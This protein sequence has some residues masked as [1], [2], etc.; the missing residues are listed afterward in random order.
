MTNKLTKKQREILYLLYRF[1]FLYRNH[2]QSLLNH[3]DHRRINSWLK[4]LVA[5][6]YI[7][8]LN[9]RESFI[10]RMTPGLYTLLPKSVKVLQENPECWIVT[11]KRITRKKNYSQTFIDSHLLIADM[12]FWANQVKKPTTKLQFL[13]ITELAGQTFFPQPLPNAYMAFSTPHNRTKRYFV[14]VLDEVMP[15]FV[16]RVRIKRYFDYAEDKEWEENTKHPFPKVLIICPNERVQKYV[17]KRVLLTQEESLEEVSFFTTT[18]TQLK[19]FEDNPNI[20][21]EVV[22]SEDSF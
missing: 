1:R 12:Y 7:R 13:T 22:E 17:Q 2:I 20:W 19:Q 3:K 21:L 16:I 14:E 9:N 18:H 11:L 5:Q 6:G 15:R 4:D 10:E 8:R